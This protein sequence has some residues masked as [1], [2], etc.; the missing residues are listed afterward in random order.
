[1]DMQTLMG[2]QD[3]IRENLYSYIQAFS[4]SVRDIFDRFEFH[5][6]IDR[7]DKCGLLYLVA[8]KFSGIDLHPDAVSNTE[9]GTVFEELIRK[10]SE[11]LRKSS[12]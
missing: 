4:P 12:F 8:E 10:F 5:T 7:L 3:H 11:I 9:M 2:D 6:Q 1:M